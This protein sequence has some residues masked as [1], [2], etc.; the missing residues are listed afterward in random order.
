MFGIHIL[1]CL[2]LL[3]GCAATDL[4]VAPVTH[5]KPVTVT[6][7]KT[8][9]IELLGG[10]VG[11]S[12]VINVVPMVAEGAVLA[13]P[14]ASGPYPELH[15]GREDQKIFI[16][17]LGNELTRLGILRVIEPSPGGEA[18]FKIRILFSQTHHFPNT[19]EYTLDVAM[20]MKGGARTYGNTY[21][22]LSSEGDS[23][24]EKATTNAVQGKTKAARKLMNALIHDIEAGLAAGN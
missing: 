7:S 9:T 18:D 12:S 3:S 2:L 23:Y 21:H 5:D 1:F 19:Q 16:S 8:A 6:S 17:S 11:G 14:I 10:V 15:F 13:L 20:E 24:W 4:R 22:I